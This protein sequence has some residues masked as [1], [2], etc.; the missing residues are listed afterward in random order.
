[1]LQ[2][3]AQEASVRGS[4]RRGRNHE[5]C[6][7]RAVAVDK[8]KA[9]RAALAAAARKSAYENVHGA[10]ERESEQNGADPRTHRG[11]GPQRRRSAWAAALNSLL[12]AVFAQLWALE[13][14]ER[15]R[16]AASAAAIELVER[17]G[18]KL[19]PRRTR[20]ALALLSLAPAHHHHHHHRFTAH[21]ANI[22]RATLCA[23]ASATRPEGGSTRR[24]VCCVCY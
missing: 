15:E 8:G 10:R 20:V 17:A 18:E 24:P 7:P 9:S 2:R 23:C 16:L 22:E 6:A 13:R 1:M 14:R 12:C 21:I 5:P 11:R 19:R 3:G 4:R